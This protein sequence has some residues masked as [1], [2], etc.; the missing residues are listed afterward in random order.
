MAPAVS[1]MNW[2]NYDSKA[3]VVGLPGLQGTARL[4]ATFR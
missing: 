3:A 4:E 2:V 1:G